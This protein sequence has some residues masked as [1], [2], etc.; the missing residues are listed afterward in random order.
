M[1]DLQISL[2]KMRCVDYKILFNCVIFKKKTP[3]LENILVAK[4]LQKKFL[5][6]SLYDEYLNNKNCYLNQQM[7]N[8]SEMLS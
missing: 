4:Q 1:H 6:S 8:F 5:K 2:M 3:P 7:N